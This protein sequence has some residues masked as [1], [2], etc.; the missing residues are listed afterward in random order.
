M[1]VIGAEK[2]IHAITLQ[3]REWIYIPEQDIE[4]NCYLYKVVQI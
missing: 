1:S 4:N 2:K 3:V